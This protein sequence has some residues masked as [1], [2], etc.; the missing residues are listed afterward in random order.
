[1]FVSRLLT[2][3]FCPPNCMFVNKYHYSVFLILSFLDILV[4]LS[5]I[6]LNPIQYEIRLTLIRRIRC[7]EECTMG[8]D[9]SLARPGSK[10]AAPVES[11]MGRGMD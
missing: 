6:S 8:A 1:M 11:V 10:Q 5:R 7:F 4:H 2:P 3:F 9:K